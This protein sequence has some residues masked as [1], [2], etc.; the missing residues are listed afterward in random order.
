M[1]E[2]AGYFT[3]GLNTDI[4]APFFFANLCA[5]LLLASVPFALR[6]YVRK[7]IVKAIRMDDWVLIA[8]YVSV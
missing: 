7:R 2:P 3:E 6:I 1:S 8:A 5:A 4:R